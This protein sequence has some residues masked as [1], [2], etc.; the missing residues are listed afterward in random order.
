MARRTKQEA[1]KTRAQILDA[2][3]Q[4][5]LQKGVASTSLQDIARKAGVTRGAVYWHFENKLALFNAMH[6]RV[7]LPMDALFEQALH[8]PS[9][10]QALKELCVYSLKQLVHDEH[11]RRV[12]TILLHRCEQVDDAKNHCE[13]QRQMREEVLS[14]LEKIFTLARKENHL[15]TS[16]QPETAALAL[17]AYMLGLFSD[18]LRNPATHP[19]PS[20]GTTLIDIFFQGMGNG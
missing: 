10:I 20:L 9:P 14:K 4:V 16:I 6:E 12:Y 5:F 2:A 17:H 3:E 11:T 8:A 15:P 18:Y 19:L 1:E 7:K 13:R